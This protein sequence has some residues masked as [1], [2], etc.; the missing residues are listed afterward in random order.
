M[1]IE[2]SDPDITERFDLEALKGRVRAAIG[3]LCEY[4]EGTN[5]GDWIESDHAS[6]IYAIAHELEK[7]LGDA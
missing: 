4:A 7:A 5:T 1:P 3:L 2:I 6:H